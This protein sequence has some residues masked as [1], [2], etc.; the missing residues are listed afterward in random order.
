MLAD[1]RV[2]FWRL[3]V[4]PPGPVDA[5]D[6]GAVPRDGEQVMINGEV[7]V[8]YGVQWRPQL[9]PPVAIVVLKTKLDYQVAADQRAGRPWAVV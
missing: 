1:M 4:S 7:L 6:M 9:E 5:V 8:A 3:D 2:E